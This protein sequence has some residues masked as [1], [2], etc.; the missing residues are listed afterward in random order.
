MKV[1]IFGLGNFGMSLAI[2]LTDTGNDVVVAD[3]NP[4]RVDLIKDQVSHAVIMDSTNE[5]AYR[6]LPLKN[7]DLVVVAIGVDEGVGI[8]TTAIAKKMCDAKIMAR[9]ASSV[10]DTIFE[11]MGVDQ[12]IHPEQEYAERLTKKI[13]LRGSIDNFEIEG[14]G[15][16]L[17][18]EV[19]VCKQ[20]VG[21]SLIQSNFRERFGLNIITILRKK[22]Y[23]NIIGRHAEKQ[24]VTGMPQPDSKFENNDILVVFG[25]SNDIDKYLKQYHADDAL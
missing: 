6:A 3:K 9:S 23:N 7:T 18:S 12:I 16:Y 4:D 20:L 8:M 11:A 10:Q 13:N 19:E 14:E 24:I 22:Q 2:H 5:N 25:K 21:K 17:I 1:V 15:N